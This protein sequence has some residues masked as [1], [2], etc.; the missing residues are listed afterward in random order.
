VRVVLEIIVVGIPAF[1]F[2][3]S[4]VEL[5]ERWCPSDRERARRERRRRIEE[6]R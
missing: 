1:L 6:S 2:A 4:L 3:I 5:A